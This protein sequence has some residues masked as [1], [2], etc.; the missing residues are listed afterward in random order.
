MLRLNRIAILVSL[1]FTLGANAQNLSPLSPAPADSQL[2]G[3]LFYQLLLGEMNAR[4]GDAS[5]A[6][7]LILDAARKTKSAEL[8]QRAV[9]IALQA[10]SGASALQAAQAWRQVVPESKKAN[11]FLFQILIG[12]NR[13]SDTLEPL[14]QELASMPAG[15]RQ[16]FIE[17]I[18]QY[19]AR[20]SDKKLAALTVEKALLQYLLD[21]SEAAT[22]W[23]SIGRM[24]FEAEEFSS[25]IEA[26]RKAQTADPSA[27][28]PV[29]LSLLMMRAK[30]HQAETLILLHL[31]KK[32]TPTIRMEYARVLLGAQRFSEAQAQL[33]IITTEY[34]DFLDAWLIQGVLQVQ[35]N[36]LNSA[37]KS[38]KKYLSLSQTDQGKPLDADRGTTQAYLS[39]AQ[40][41]ELRKDYPGADAWLGRIDSKDDILSAQLRRA[42]LMAK[43]HDVDGALRLIRG[44]GERS[45]ADARLKIATEVQ[46]L[47][48][49]KQYAA[50]YKVLVEATNRKPSDWDFVYDMAMVVEKMGN[51]A[52]MERLLRSIITAK[53]D[54]HHAYNALGYSLAD[55]GLKLPEAKQLIL[56]ALEYSKDDP[57]IMDSLGWVEFRS[58]NLEVALSILQGAF[59]TKPDAEIAAHLGEV[60]WTMGKHQEAI[61]V[62]KKGSLLNPEN[63]TLIETVK[64]L[65]VKW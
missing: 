61:G 7:S 54:Y 36:D 56:K 50:A 47:R 41:A 37:E 20:T 18:P 39:L 10:R 62:W 46:I 19:Y 9:E 48:D 28:G 26:T 55:Q 6:Y 52:E 15:G 58:G 34:P 32:P 49:D 42:V 57:F 1:A 59:R 40:I 24:R 44:Q 29:L 5:A 12:L 30:V 16:A 11:S 51:M 65:G 33:Q 17:S 23:T 43:Q 45:E 63:N 21:P 60:M 38:L 25:A 8:F 14:K 4:G 3:P 35:E 13:I 64:R 53:P 2:D 22:A 27:E 31:D